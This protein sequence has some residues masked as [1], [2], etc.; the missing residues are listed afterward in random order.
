MAVEA[1]VNGLMAR[2]AELGVAVEE[3][4]FPPPIRW[5]QGFAFADSAGVCVALDE[6]LSPEE[7]SVA[8]A[9][10]LGS[11]ERFLARGQAC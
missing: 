10:G 9:R 7:K 2:A 3:V 6:G 4:D 5:L 8:L 11:A 1:G